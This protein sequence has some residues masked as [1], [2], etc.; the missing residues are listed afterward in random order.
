[1]HERKVNSI[2]HTIL[3]NYTQQVFDTPEEAGHIQLSSEGKYGWQMPLDSATAFVLKDCQGKTLMD[4]GCGLG[5]TVTI[6][7]LQ[8][9]ASKVIAVD[10]TP[11][12]VNNESKLAQFEREAGTENRLRRVLIDETWWNKPLNQSPCM[13]NLLNF[14]LTEFVEKP[15]LDMVV[16]RHSMQFG[17][18]HS[19][20]NVFD[21]A[22]SVLKPGGKL[23]SINFTP[24]TE[25]VYQYD[26]GNLLRDITS[27]NEKYALGEVDLPGGFLDKQQGILGVS[28]K[29]I[30]Q[31][32]DIA[33]D[34]GTFI[35]LDE[36]TVQ[37]LHRDWLSSR[38]ARALPEDLQIINGF[39][40]SPD[41]ITAF[42]KLISGDPS[43]H[44]RE[45]Y[46]FVIEKQ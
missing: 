28:L 17:N 16:A 40:F 44:K 2:D 18:P 35:Y 29:Q 34:H 32:T 45:N 10:V 20:L 23:Y 12:H 1:M 11:E 15:Q 42:N 22:S 39:Y 9:N 26:Q 7:A 46:L 21:L 27:L 36:P 43:L 4:L 38:R 25:Y 24:Y 5:G 19:I 33:E 14:S 37:G 30:I 6:P 41:K 3:G 13:E 31:R 8:K